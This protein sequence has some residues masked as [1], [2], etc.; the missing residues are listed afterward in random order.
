ME[1][2][3]ESLMNAA[4]LLL[5]KCRK[6]L[7][8]GKLDDLKKRCTKEQDDVLRMEGNL[9]SKLRRDY[10][11]RLVEEREEAEKAA[12]ELQLAEKELAEL[13]K[14]IAALEGKYENVSSIYNMEEL[15]DTEKELH[16]WCA[17][18]EQA[19]IVIA[20]TNK[21]LRE[22]WAERVC[23]YSNPGNLDNCIAFQEDLEELYRIMDGFLSA[24]GRVRYLPGI[25]VKHK[26]L[27]QRSSRTT[28][29]G[30]KTLVFLRKGRD[31][32]QI[33]L[34]E[35]DFKNLWGGWAVGDA[36]ERK[37]REIEQLRRLFFEIVEETMAQGEE[38]LRK[39]RI[40]H[41]QPVEKDIFG[42]EK[43]Y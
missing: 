21:C 19:F 36:L 27:L 17:F 42:F 2:R 15:D 4:E 43:K 20:L 23:S 24:V 9:F 26:A 30:G 34:H 18:M 37:L 33:D 40:Q 31:A 16:D 14:W 41:F 38:L 29:Y 32:V 5:F 12:L 10:E 25:R 6:E 22:G 11:E 3:V 28:Y 7:Y 1:M 39:V 13:E 8:F 35:L